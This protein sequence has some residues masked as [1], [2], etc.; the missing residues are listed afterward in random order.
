MSDNILNV[1]TYETAEIIKNVKCFKN[2]TL[3]KQFDSFKEG[4]KV[5]AICITLELFIWDDD[6][7]LVGNDTITI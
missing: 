1:F 3:L 6:G 5:A 4:D 7:E 2:C